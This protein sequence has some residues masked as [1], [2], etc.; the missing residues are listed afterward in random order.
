MKSFEKTLWLAVVLQVAGLVLDGA[1]LLAGG[2][3]AV[4]IVI[5]FTAAGL[6]V[7]LAAARREVLSRRADEEQRDLAA[8]DSGGQSLFEPDPEAAAAFS[9][10]QQLRQFD[11]YLMPVVTPA[12]VL[13]CG[14]GA[15][16]LA[17]AARAG[18]TDPPG[19]LAAGFLGARAFAVFLLH[20]VLLISARISTGSRVRAP[21]IWL[22]LT[23]LASAFAAI[24]IMADAWA[25]TRMAVPAMLAAAVLAALLAL[26]ALLLSVA[27]LYR[28]QA[29]RQRLA[30][31]R[32]GALVCDPAS[33]AHSLAGVL[34]Y[35][36]GFR[37]SETWLFR[38]VRRLLLPMLGLQ[39]LLLL[40]SHCI[41]II[42][43]HEAAIVE[44]L[45]RPV[46][47]RVLHSGFHLVAPPPW[48]RVRRYPM[49][50][51][52]TIQVGF[53]H[54]DDNGH[55]H[56]HH[57]AHD[58]EIVLWT[59][60]HHDDEHDFLVAARDQ[61]ARRTDTAAVPV[62]LLSISMTVDYQVTDLL[63]YLTVHRDPESLLRH[64]A[65]RSLMI[66]AVHAD[67]FDLMGPGQQA[68]AARLAQ[69]LDRQARQL[70]MG[71]TIR[72]VALRGIHPPVAVAAAFEAVIG[73]D[74]MYQ[75]ALL[76]GQTYRIRRLPAANAEAYAVRR[77]AEAAR[78][79][80]RTTAAAE[81]ELFRQRTRAAAM[82]PAVY[83]PRA[84]LDVLEERLSLTTRHLVVAVTDSEVVQLDFS[85]KPYSALLDAAGRL[86]TAD[87]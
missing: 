41:L 74:D 3:A 35:Q 21:A 10:G 45:G 65:L 84:L 44:V 29:A 36:F 87:P 72:N 43:P 52:Q 25:G 31:S 12:L 73:A 4:R 56:H 60:D 81:A 20:R 86:G 30:E 53:H 49:H 66:E 58:D 39:L 83:R 38:T 8:A 9:A 32:L 75:T 22:G 62:N 24:V 1:W 42:E 70:D 50:R 67:V 13:I 78:D 17:W 82:A 80:R 5:P 47:E 76:E 57:A 54:Q 23:A 69:R 85:V 77:S 68:L 14:V 37:I 64:T 61:D 18:L 28:S 34:D 15:V 2:V 7:C 59:E 27:S 11:R 16:W 55:A 40:L 48:Q 26:E 71:L 46:P 63:R 33:W 51:I 19:A 6:A 79:S